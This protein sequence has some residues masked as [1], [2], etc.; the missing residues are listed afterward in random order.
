MSVGVVILLLV[1]PG[2]A[3][4]PLVTGIVSAASRSL[5]TSS[6]VLVDSRAATSSPCDGSRAVASLCMRIGVDKRDGPTA[7][8]RSKI[9]MRWTNEAARSGSP[10]LRW[11][12]PRSLVRRP[13]FL[14]PS[15]NESRVRPPPFL[16]PSRNESRDRIPPSRH[17]LR[18]RS[19]R[20]PGRGPHDPSRWRPARRCRSQPMRRPSGPFFAARSR[21]RRH[22]RSRQP[23]DGAPAR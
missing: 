20:R 16:R 13:R 8:S 17:R 10:L 6:R 4:A 18:L 1:P 22:F 11:S 2:E 5:G 3:Q 14:C 12:K 23:P 15:R 7:S 9:P 19:R 21:L